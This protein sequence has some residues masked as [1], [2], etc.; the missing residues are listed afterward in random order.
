MGFHKSP[1]KIHTNTIEIPTSRDYVCRDFEALTVVGLGDE[2][3]ILE[4][5]QFEGSVMISVKLEQLQSPEK[6]PD[7]IQSWANVIL[8]L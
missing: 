5:P 6:D 7:E 4:V 1:I 3:F 8:P 2:Q